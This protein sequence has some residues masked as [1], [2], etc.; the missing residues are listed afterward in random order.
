MLSPSPS[1]VAG[2]I[3]PVS[4]HL[5]LLRTF[6]QESFKVNC[7]QA[8]VQSQEVPLNCYIYLCRELVTFWLHLTLIQSG[9]S[10]R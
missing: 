2:Q 8:K 5:S 4:A 10:A 6:L 9:N 3:F 1:I 7:R